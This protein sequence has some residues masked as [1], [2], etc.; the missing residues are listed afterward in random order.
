VFENTTED[1]CNAPRSYLHRSDIT[2]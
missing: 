1:Y 2:K